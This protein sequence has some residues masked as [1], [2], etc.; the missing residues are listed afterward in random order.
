MT[1]LSENFIEEFVT[2]NEQ[3]IEFEKLQPAYYQIGFICSVQAQ[4][5]LL[6]LDEWL[7]YLWKENECISFEDEKQATEYAENILSFVSEIQ[8]LYQQ[9]LPLSAL[10]C[11][12][13]LDDKGQISTNALQFATGFLNAIELFNEHWVSVENHES[14]EN[15]LQTSILLLSK[16][17]PIEDQ[18]PQMQA[19]FTQLPN[20]DEILK[21]LPQLLS[22]LAY[23]AAQTVDLEY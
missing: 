11:E 2:F 17:T 10:N 16:I 23:G 5:S 7:H 13:W 6:E 3:H 15:L 22:N 18:D 4:P 19:I 14:T 12:N 21:I 1:N 8:A 20:F 9:A